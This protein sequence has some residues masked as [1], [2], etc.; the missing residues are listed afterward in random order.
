MNVCKEGQK[1]SKRRPIFAQGTVTWRVK[2][3]AWRAGGEKIKVLRKAHGGVTP[4]PCIVVWTCAKKAKK[5][6][7]VGQFLPKAPSLEALSP[8]HGARGAKKSKC[9]EKLSHFRFQLNI[10]CGGVHTKNQL[11][12]QFLGG[13]LRRIRLVTMFRPKNQN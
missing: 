11:K 1:N 4:P 13:D 2:P 10:L 12:I 5:I 8:W 3:V 7:S 9:S 6:P